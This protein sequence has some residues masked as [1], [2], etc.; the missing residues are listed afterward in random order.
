MAQTLS[1][2]AL[3]TKAMKNGRISGLSHDQSSI[4]ADFGPE[5]FWKKIIGETNVDD[6]LQRLDLLTREES[7][8]AVANILGL[9]DHVD[10]NVEQIKAFAEST[11]GNVEQIKAFAES[12]DDNVE[13]IKAFAES[14]DGNVEQIKVLAESTGGN[15][16]QIKILAENTDDNVE[17]IKVL[18]ESTNGRVQEI[19]QTVK[20][21][22]ER[23]R[24]FLSSFTYV[25]TLL[26][27]ASQNRNR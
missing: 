25:P 7:L 19:D 6:A 3:S 1:I 24:Y 16:G 18:A 9:A 4:L 14:T 10:G 11:D 12:T 5:K 8:M 17:Q 22:E 13:Q 27:I 26:S 15:V 20:A 23:T 2:L 21:V